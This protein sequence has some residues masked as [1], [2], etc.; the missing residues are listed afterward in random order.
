EGLHSLKGVRYLHP[1]VARPR[2]EKDYRLL[3]AP[4]ATLEA[5][6]GLVHTAPGHGAEDYAVGRDQGLDIYAPVDAAGPCPREVAAWAGLAV[7]EWNPKVVAALADQ[8]FLLNKPGETLRHSYPHCWRCKSPV[9]FRA[10]SQWFARLGERGDPHSLRERALAEIDR[11][12][13]I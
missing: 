2:S 1:F 13:W 9:I 4:H 12:T 5:G 8:G 11:T 7:W 3:F 10:T 6:T